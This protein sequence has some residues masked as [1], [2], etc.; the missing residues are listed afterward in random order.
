MARRRPFF[1][2]F[3]GYLLLIGALLSTLLLWLDIIGVADSRTMFMP[4]FVALGLA[5]ESPTMSSPGELFLE[6]ERIQKEREEI[7]LRS[8]EIDQKSQELESR[9]LELDAK[10]SALNEKEKSLLEREIALQSRLQRYDNKRANLETVSRYLTGM[11]PADA[12]RI[13]SA[14]SD[15]DMIDVLRVTEELAAQQGEQS[16]VSFWLSL[17]SR[18]G[19]EGAARAAEIQVKLVRRPD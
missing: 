7:Q 18:T 12:V 9:K 5:P 11:P 19:Q 3:L 14:M 16:L 10:E 1:S 2:R 15:Q 4:V 8:E 17:L 6:N 13:L